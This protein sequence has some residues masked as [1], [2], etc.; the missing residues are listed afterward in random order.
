METRSEAPVTLIL[1]YVSPWVIG[2]L[3]IQLTKNAK[4]PI[5]FLPMSEAV[6]E[7]GALLGY[8]LTLKYW[9]Y[10]LLDPKK[11]PQFQEDHN[12]WKKID[13][14]TNVEVLLPHD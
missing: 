8:I 2:A 1:T 3:E 9:D 5:P 13:P 7:E 11:F 14:V 10:N 4:Y 12:M 6:L